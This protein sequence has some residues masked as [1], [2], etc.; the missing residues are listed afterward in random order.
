MSPAPI[1]SLPAAFED[2]RMSCT[3]PRASFIRALALTAIALAA[4]G[5]SQATEAFSEAG[6]QVDRLETAIQAQEAIRAVK[7]LQYSYAHY[8]ESGLWSDAAD[9]FTDGAVGEFPSGTVSGK[10]ALRKHFMEKAGRKSAGLAQGQLNLHLNLQPIV[11]LGGDGKTAKGTWHEVAMLGKF[12]TSAE[13]QGGVYENEYALDKGVWKIS[14]LRYFT[15]YAGTYEEYGHKAPAKWNIPYHFEAAH[16]GL[17]IPQSALQSPAAALSKNPFGAVDTS[18]E[19]LR[20]LD[21]RMSRMRAETEVRNL[22]NSYGYYMDRKVWDDVADLFASD[23]TL[24]IGQRGVYGGRERIRRALETFYGPH[25]LKKGELFD[26]I[27]VGAVVTV[28]RDGMSARARVTQLSQLGVNGEWARWEG[29]TYENE[30]VKEQDVWRI[31]AIRY[32]PRF[33]TDYDL[34]WARDVQPAPAV[35][36]DFPPD[37]PPSEKFESYPKQHTVGFHYTHPVTGREVRYPAGPRVRVALMKPFKD[38]PFLNIASF[39]HRSGPDDVQ[40]KLDA[41]IAVDAVENL[42]SAYG[43]YIDESAWD[44]MADTFASTGSKE[45]TGAGVYIGPDRIRKVLNLRGP[46]GGRTANFYTIHQLTQPVI[47]ISEDGTSAKARMRLFQMGGSAEGSTGSWIGGVY[48]NTAVKENGEWKFGVQDLHHIFNASYRN[49]W[50][51]VGA[52]TTPLPGKQKS[53]RDTR[54]GGITQ[55]LGGAS[56]ASRFAT[57]FPPDKP[58]RAR[59]YAFPEIT[60][61]GFHYRNPVSGRMPAELVNE[62][63]R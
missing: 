27:N 39:P 56:S 41:E 40:R 47:H 5:L 53:D 54:G 55:G 62:Q 21:R 52:V 34:G 37:R 7:R 46:R 38:K 13:W 26:H 60:E 44:N 35:S 48:E 28:S 51:R 23:G 49:G 24:E 3:S 43:Y 45:I 15:Q 61:V 18:A 29:G 20:Y 63:L 25:P 12:G 22:H 42:N 31:K 9:L 32:F 14:R 59:Q 4:P 57:E 8:L 19:R 30:F 6:R 10:A 1:W 36:R 2:V 17:T 58:I 50:A 16:V 33:S 11:T